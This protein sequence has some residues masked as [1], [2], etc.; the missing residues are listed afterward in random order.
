MCQ[1]C[2]CSQVGAVTIDGIEM[3]AHSH[4]DTHGHAHDHMHDH[5]HI[6]SPSHSPTLPPDHPSTH[7]P[8]HPHTHPPD[9]N[10]SHTLT[11]H[12]GILSKNDRLAAQNRESFKA[13]GVLVLNVLSSPGAG[14]TALIER[15]AQDLAAQT[16]QDGPQS[17]KMGVVV[18][19]LATDNDAQRL[20]Q[21]G[22]PAVQITTGNA[23]HLEAEM[24]AQSLTR[25]D[26]W[27]EFDLLVI[28]N[29]G[30]LVCPT[31]Y[32]LGE[33]LRVVLLSTTEGEDKPLKYPATFKSADVVLLTK[34]DIA[35][36]VGCDRT[37]ALS[38][39]Q[40]V[41]PQ[42]KVFEVSAR[43]GAGLSDWYEYLVG[44]L[45]LL[46]NKPVGCCIALRAWLR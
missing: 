46:E 33:T 27:P 3:P 36:A 15:L 32:D 1:N 28:E 29:V 10:H 11:V 16:P 2:G 23:C 35:E 31:S 9:H 14:K 17:L 41:A 43:T 30:N 26:Q 8:I 21:A 39:I 25:L 38:N 42:A 45:V 7:P 44:Q 19:D 34:V 12:Q 37:L 5:P 4:E 24:V 20:R 6:H 18:G 22:A 13:A 40:R